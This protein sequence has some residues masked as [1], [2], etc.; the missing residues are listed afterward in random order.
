MYDA[1]FAGLTWPE[2]Y[3]GKGAPYSHQAIALEECARALG[4][5]LIFEAYF[6]QERGR[7]HRSSLSVERTKRASAGRWIATPGSV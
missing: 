3:G 2:E 6:G 4:R 7:G 1:G 5:W